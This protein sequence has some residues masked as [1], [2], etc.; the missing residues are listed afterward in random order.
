M[1]GLSLCSHP[2]HAATEKYLFN[3]CEQQC[4]F[5]EARMYSARRASIL[6]IPVKRKTLLTLPC[7]GS[8]AFPV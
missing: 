4:A 5:L 7:S 6:L 1:A 2:S 3:V 8:G